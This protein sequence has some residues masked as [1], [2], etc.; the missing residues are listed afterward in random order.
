MQIRCWLLIILKLYHNNL[1]KEDFGLLLMK[2]V[3]LQYNLPKITRES[4][5]SNL[6]KQFSSLSNGIMIG[7]DSLKKSDVFGELISPYFLSR[8]LGFGIEMYPESLTLDSFFKAAGIPDIVYGSRKEYF[9]VDNVLSDHGKMLKQRP[10][11]LFVC[12]H[13]VNKVK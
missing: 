10:S 12:K 7:L 1:F 9:L 6:A 8:D 11:G 2:P 13:V 4:S 3:I 5:P